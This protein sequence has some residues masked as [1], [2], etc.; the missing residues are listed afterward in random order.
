[1]SLLIAVPCLDSVDTDFM[2]SMISLRKPEGTR[3]AV[4]KNSM[5]YDSR[6]SIASKAIVSETS[7]DPADRYDRVLWIDSDMV[8]NPDLISRLNADMDTGLDYVCGLCFVRK[9]PTYPVVYSEIK[10]WIDQDGPHAEAVK[11]PDYPKNQLFRIAGSG[12]GCVMTSTKLL[13]DVWDHFGPP[14]DPMS[15]MGEDLTFCYH[16][17]QL[18]YEMYCDS[19][20]KVGHVGS[21]TYDE[22]VYFG[23]HMR[24]AKQ[25]T[26]TIPEGM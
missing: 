25:K 24:E 19:R 26:E 1:M 21:F 10:Y 14:F 22:N 4:M 17:N 3:F 6:N 9:L 16:A 13:K 8:F 23:Q 12:F 2:T 20:V 18:G 11:M 7:E 15:H 5:I